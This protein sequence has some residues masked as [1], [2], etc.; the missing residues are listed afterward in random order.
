[1]KRIWAIRNNSLIIRN[2]LIFPAL[3]LESIKIPDT[4][5]ISG[6][7]SLMEGVLKGQITLQ[8]MVPFSAFVGLWLLIGWDLRTLGHPYAHISPCILDKPHIGGKRNEW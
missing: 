1:M 3:A 8:K 6:F 2:R 5:L 4:K 7:I